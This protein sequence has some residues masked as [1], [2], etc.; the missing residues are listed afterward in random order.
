MFITML[1][2][3]VMGDIVVQTQAQN[4]INFGVCFPGCVTGCATEKFPKLLLCPI[5]CLGACLLPPLIL[6]K[7]I[8]R[9]DYYCKLG[10]ATHHSY[11][12]KVVDCVD[13]CSNKWSNKN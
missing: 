3:M 10:C 11:A 1:V 9:I 5:T 6:A 4:T 2:V 13:S 12:K 7:E 8:D